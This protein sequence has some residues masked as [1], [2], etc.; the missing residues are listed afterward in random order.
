MSWAEAVA[1]ALAWAPP[2]VGAVL[3]DARADAPWRAELA[4]Q[5]PSPSLG[6]CLHLFDDA[7]SMASSAH[8]QP[9]L[10]ALI[11]ALGHDAPGEHRVDRFARRVLRT[12]LEQRD[13]REA[14]RGALVVA[15]AMPP[16]HVVNES[17]RERKSSRG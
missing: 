12:A 16:L 4:M 1:E 9:T 8:G 17:P 3:K 2:R 11:V 10:D 14:R 15:G 13:T 5:E 6:R 7:V